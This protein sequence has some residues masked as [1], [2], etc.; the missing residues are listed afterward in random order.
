M[1]PFVIIVLGLYL[2]AHIYIYWHLRSALP[3]GRGP[4]R[5]AALILLILFAT[6]FLSGFGRRLLPPSL[7]GRLWQAG[8]WWF[9]FVFYAFL[10]LILADLARVITWLVRIFRD[11]P[12]KA[13]FPAVRR[14]WILAG[15]LA[16]ILLL[17]VGHLNARHLRVATHRIALGPSCGPLRSLDLVLISDLHLGT[18]VGPHFLETV[19]EKTAALRPDLVVLAGDILDHRIPA[20]EAERL[21]ELLA[22][23]RG[24]LGVYAVTG[25]HE[26]ITGADQAVEYLSGRGITFLRDRAVKIEGSFYLAGREDVTVRRRSGSEVPLREILDGLDRDCPVILLDHQPRRI[27][28][29]VEEGVALVF[30]GHTHHGQLFPINLVTSALYPVS[31]GWGKLGETQVYVTGGAGTWGPPVRIG[32]TPEIVHLKIEFQ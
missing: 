26:F 10:I 9:G 17:F 4:R 24:R 3:A 29:A 13:G 22:R 14:E 25:N 21:G 12:G 30:C 20:P 27:G 7:A 5:A 23:L 1:P 15:G 32:N 19:V 18:V 8:A 16:V 11:G 2:A 28:E 31:W 6:L